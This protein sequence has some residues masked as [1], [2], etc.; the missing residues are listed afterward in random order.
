MQFDPTKYERSYRPNFELVQAFWWEQGVLASGIGALAF[1]ASHGFSVWSAW[2][3]SAAVCA[4]MTLYRRHQA[5]KVNEQDKKLRGE[6]LVFTDFAALKEKVF[7][8]FKS[9]MTYEEIKGTSKAVWL[10]RG[11]MWEKDQIQR[12][13]EIMSGTLESLDLQPAGDNS[14]GFSDKTGEAAKK[15]FTAI[16]GLGE[17]TDIYQP[18]SHI[19]GHTLILGTTGA[20][21]TRLFDLLI[22]QAV[23]RG[24]AVLIFD[25]KGDEELEKN[26]KR[27]CEVIGKPQLF[28]SVRL[29]DPKHSAKIDPLA[30]FEETAE[31]ASRIKCLLGPNDD[32]FTKYAAAFATSIFEGMMTAGEKPTLENLFKY[33]QS[34]SLASLVSR[35]VASLASQKEEFE[36]NLRI[37]LPTN[38]FPEGITG[39]DVI[40]GSVSLSGN[41]KRAAVILTDFQKAQYWAAYFRHFLLED[42]TRTVRN[43]ASVISF[44]EHDPEHLSKML[45]NLTA[46]LT[47]LTSGEV[48]TIVNPK[49][50]APGA[51]FLNLKDLTHGR[52][53]VY[54]GLD[55]LQYQSAGR[56]LGAI[57]LSD[58]A[59]VAADR[60]NYRRDL[61][62]LNIFV[63]ECAEIAND[64]LIALLNKGRGAKF[65][66][67]CASQ[68]IADFTTRLESRDKT[69][70]AL[71][72][73]NNMICLRL[74]SAE[75]MKYFADNCMKTKINYVMHTQSTG[76][77]SDDPLTASANSGERLMQEEAELVPPQALG[78]L[79]D[80]EY[81]ASLSGGKIFKGRLPILS[82]QGADHERSEVTEAK[83]KQG[84]KAKEKGTLFE[85]V[86][87]RC[88]LMS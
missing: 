9:G 3:V 25:P 15:G 11:F 6:E 49:P 4:A 10:G 52:R 76:I 16:H 80:L 44:F 81:F 8:D 26:A 38:E 86:A 59:Q 62:P 67:Y 7:P 54:I 63:D 2:S 22:S 64:P 5:V 77:S 23:L 58:L 68:T 32:V 69:E 53:V 19:S 33:V 1:Y 37:A 39:I 57:L 12:L 30:N 83:A 88:L 17:E 42:E 21:K 41:K 34:G 48:G 14:G 78:M 29:N 73:F 82:E 40:K 60:Y 66:I 13:T 28:V 55:T 31:L 72:N 84:A 45:S 18:L 56:A 61:E 70:S 74:R 43:A 87:K 65:Q 46:A 85:K 47:D 75:T 79:P 71:G 50:H 20:G 27:A 35:M 36:N 24:E 51:N